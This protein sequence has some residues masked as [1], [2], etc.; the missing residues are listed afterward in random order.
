MMRAKR[1]D[2]LLALLACAPLTF[3]V[4]AFAY[5]DQPDGGIPRVGGN[6]SGKKMINTPPSPLLDL[7]TLQQHAEFA[8]RLADAARAEIIPYWRQSRNVLG[9]QIKVETDRSVSQSA[10][11]VTL[12]DRAAERA[13]RDIIMETYP[14]HGIYGE[15]FGVKDA[16]ADFVW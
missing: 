13:M 10:S 8:N 16:D 5:V 15:E 7:D 12:A 2:V 11:P 6:A 9:Q 3:L 4:D 14:E 1:I